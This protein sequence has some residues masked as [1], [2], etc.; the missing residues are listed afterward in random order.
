MAA[1]V[2]WYRDAWWIRV[3]HKGRKKDRRIGPTKADKK[4][5][6]EI[7]AK[8]NA[9]LA[10][11]QY[12]AT[13]AQD[14]PLAC[15]VALKRWHCTYSATMKPSYEAHTDRLI[16]NHLIPFFGASDLR[17]LGEEDLLRYI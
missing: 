15:D 8:L 11:G 10:L 7:A 3:H 12:S 17:E 9:A 16:E 6:G 2:V 14:E 1:K 13:A 5:A 4:Q